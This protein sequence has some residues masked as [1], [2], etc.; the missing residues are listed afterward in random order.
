VYYTPA[1]EWRL[2]FVSEDR[3][4]TLRGLNMTDGTLELDLTE[5]TG[6][7]GTMSTGKPFPTIVLDRYSTS[8]TSVL[9]VYYPNFDRTGYKA[10]ENLPAKGTR[11]LA[12]DDLNGDG[13]LD[14]VLANA[15]YSGTNPDSQI[16][17]GKH[18]GTWDTDNPFN[19]GATR[20]FRAAIGDFNGDSHPDIVLGCYHASLSVSS[21]IFLNNGDG[22]FD[23]QADITFTDE[24]YY[25]CAAGDLNG[26]GYDDIVFS[27]TTDAVCYYGGPNGPDKVKD[28][29]WNP[30]GYVYRVIIEDL[31]ADGNLDVILG[32]EDGTDR[33]PVYMGSSS[34][35]DTTPDFYLDVGTS[36]VPFG[37]TAGDLNADG[38]M[39]V[40]LMTTDNFNHKLYVYEGSSTGYDG[41]SPHKISIGGY[42]YAMEVADI[43]MDGYGDLIIGYTNNMRVYYGGDSLPTDPDITKAG[44]DNPYSLVVATGS[45]ASTRK[46]AGRIVTE[47]INK[48]VGK[49]WDTLVLEGTIPKNS[50]FRITVQDSTGRPLA[51]FEDRTDMNIDLQGLTT[52]AIKVDLWLESDLNTS[53]PVIDLL[54]V[55]WQDKD[56]WREQFFGNAKVDRTMGTIVEDGRLN[57]LAGG[58]STPDLL[59]A[60]MLA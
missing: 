34:G 48:P 39:E 13:Y 41:N 60:G 27:A 2:D 58:I 52:P 40:I 24:E 35:V 30:N 32:Y 17:W 15:Y 55:K 3:I 49:V 6:I 11:A 54:R 36:S 5:N 50:S 19:L 45:K 7:V 16:L 20:A 28:I 43:N 33:M 53:T 23:N 12:M 21:V 37:V 31:D 29:E 10:K 46:F 38:Y 14:L 26:D 1:D 22:T 56:M 59:F 4:E 8:G 42:C 9:D 51:G 57:V 18:D 25:R 47:Q 44:P